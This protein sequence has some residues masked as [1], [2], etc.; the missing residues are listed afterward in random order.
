LT[1][2]E[3][4]EFID[5]SLLLDLLVSLVDIQA[6]YLT[7][8]ADWL[9]SMTAFEFADKIWK[10]SELTNR[11]V[12]VISRATLGV[13][14]GEVSALFF[15]DYLKS[16]GGLGNI[17]S[18]LKDGAQ[19]LCAALGFQTIA[20]GM[21]ADLEVHL[22]SP[23]TRIVQTDEG[24]AIHTSN[25][26]TYNTQKVIFS[27]PTALYH[28][29]DFEPALP[30]AKQELSNATVLGYYSKTIL[31]FDEPWW[32]DAN[33]TGVFTSEGPIAFTRDTSAGGQNSITC[34][35]V[36]EPGR[37]WSRLDAGERRETVLVQ[38]RRAFGEFVD[39]V[40]EPVQVLEKEWTKEPWARGAPSPVMPPG[41]L[42]SDAGLSMREPFGHVHFVGTETAFEWKGYLEGAVPSGER[43]A[44]EVIEKL[45]GC[46]QRS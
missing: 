43:G 18:D 36:G 8:G 19:Y 31:I 12:N 15:L 27:A 30:A 2:E 6:S 26:V 28:L 25:N 44:H 41:I 7:L 34:F 38:F 14:S 4:A 24:V 29:V 5:I 35:H 10:S 22:S 23:V 32:R 13:E 45:E 21:A 46:R 37:Q 11:L 16:G 33:L 1:E 42:T 17:T 3:Q 39:E 9:D 20:D 40:P